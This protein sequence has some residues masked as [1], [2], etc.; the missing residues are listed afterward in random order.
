M[1]NSNNW[2]DFI[3]TD[4]ADYAI[5]G[6][7]IEMF[8]NSWNDMYTSE[9]LGYTIN[10]MGYVLQI[11]S[12]SYGCRIPASMMVGRTGYSE[13]LYY[14]HQEEIDSNNCLRYFLA[15]PMGKSSSESVIG[16]VSYDGYIGN[17]GY[18]STN[19]TKSAFRPL[20]SLK[21]GSKLKRDSNGNYEIMENE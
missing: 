13:A 3:N 2:T 19:N 11:T 18:T 12:G 21:P 15:S 4:Y 1:L 20:V 16:F 8:V 7:T 6:P 14:P 9:K 10:K 5:G 17:D